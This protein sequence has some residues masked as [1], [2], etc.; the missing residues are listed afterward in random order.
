M[1]EEALVDGLLRALR[2]RDR[3][4]LA[5]TLHRRVTLVGDTGSGS[6]VSARGRRATVAALFA[7]CAPDAA[8]ELARVNGHAGLL[9]RNPTGG[10]VGVLAVAVLRDRVSE[11]WATLAPEKLE[12]WGK[13]LPT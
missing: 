2:S 10:V 3:R 13:R 8:V 5:R 4:A 11:I 7:L 1:G 9:L 12:T 6:G